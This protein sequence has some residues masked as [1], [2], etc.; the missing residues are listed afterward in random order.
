MYSKKKFYHNVLVLHLIQCRWRPWQ[1][2]NFCKTMTLQ[3]LNVKLE[4]CGKTFLEGYMA[5]K[6][7]FELGPA[8][9]I[10]YPYQLNSDTYFIFFR[11]AKYIFLHQSLVDSAVI[12]TLNLIGMTTVRSPA[13]AIGRWLKPL[14]VRTDPRTS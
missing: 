6:C 10:Q 8:Y 3:E 5:K 1:G 7:R 13:I 4:H 12:L 14:Y 9:Y 2:R 11:S